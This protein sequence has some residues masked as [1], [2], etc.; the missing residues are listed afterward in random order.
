MPDELRGRVMSL[1]MLDRGFM[2]AGRYLPAPRRI[3][4][5]RRMTVATMGAIVILLTLV[6]AWRIRRSVLLKVEVSLLLNR[7]IVAIRDRPR[8]N[9][10]SFFLIST[11][12]GPRRSFLSCVGSRKLGECSCSVC[13]FSA[14]HWLHALT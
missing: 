10:F 7:Q 4:S 2:P 11:T 8:V 3:S 12:A 6:V 9:L 1:Y 13:A 14:R 5:A